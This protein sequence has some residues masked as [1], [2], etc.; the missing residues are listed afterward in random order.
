MVGTVGSK[1]CRFP[2][3]SPL[4]PCRKRSLSY[5]PKR[6]QSWESKLA[7]TVAMVSGFV[8]E[9]KWQTHE[10]T[11]RDKLTRM[12][13]QTGL[14]RRQSWFH[15]CFSG[16]T[17]WP[18]TRDVPP[19]GGASPLSI[20]TVPVPPSIC[21]SPPPLFTVTRSARHARTLPAKRGAFPSAAVAI[22]IAHRWPEL[23]E[24]TG[25]PGQERNG[26]KLPRPSRRER[27]TLESPT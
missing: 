1:S 4:T 8:H 14:Q 27:Q 9:E 19:L 18:V 16:A 6:K 25:Y 20:P 10:S 22:S 5:Q 12:T 26:V 17:S 11:T 21:S 23:H 2:S 15:Q 3:A 13:F 7:T 24:T